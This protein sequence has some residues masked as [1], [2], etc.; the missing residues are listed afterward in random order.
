[1]A[2]ETDS[3]FDGASPHAF[4]S[5]SSQDYEDLFMPTEDLDLLMP[6]V[7]ELE[8]LPSQPPMSSHASNRNAHEPDIGAAQ[9]NTAENTIGSCDRE[10]TSVEKNGKEPKDVRVSKAARYRGGE[11]ELT[12]SEMSDR[13]KALLKDDG[14]KKEDA[15][16]EKQKPESPK[17]PSPGATDTEIIIKQE[18]KNS[19]PI[20]DQGT[21]AEVIDLSD[22]V[23]V[24]EIPRHMRNYKYGTT[25][26]D[27][28]ILLSDGEDD[29]EI[30]IVYD[31]GST[32]ITNKQE[33]PEV[34]FL[35]ASKSLVDLPQS[36]SS[37]EEEP[38]LAPKPKLD[39]SILRTP[40]PRVKRTPADIE[41][42]KRMQRLYAARALDKRVVTG[43]GGIFRTPRT[44]QNP[45]TT[46]S[47]SSRHTDSDDTFAWMSDTVI[48]DE[49]RGTGFLEL[50]R[51]YKAKRKARKNTLVDDVEFK[52]AQ[53]EENDRIRKLA[54]ETADSESDE[55]EESDDGLFVSQREPTSS[56]LKRPFGSIIGDFDDADDE[57]AG[58]D[59]PA[60]KKQKNN[61]PS[62]K[63]DYSNKRARAKALEKETRSNM[64]AGIE[65]YLLRDQKNAEDKAAKEAEIEDAKNGKGRKKGL[66][67]KKSGK[68]AK[69]V[70]P[71]RTATGRMN[72]V[73][74]LLT[75]NVYDDSNANLDCNSLPVITEKK[76]K[77]FLSSLIA[78]VPLEDQ[79]QARSDRI[80]VVRASK[81][82]SPRNV[83]PDGKGD[84]HLTGMKTSLYHYQVQGAAYMKKRETGDQEP[85]GG[86]LAGMSK[87]VL[88]LFAPYLGSGIICRED[89]SN[90]KHVSSLITHADFG[91]CRSDGLRQDC[92]DDCD[93]DCESRNSGKRA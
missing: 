49:N 39:N 65:A 20:S 21:P 19:L 46:D 26:Q 68:N 87:V 71:T 48:Q 57:V 7:M 29:Q 25:M 69:K 28:T 54:Q 22:S 89:S 75:S 37:A 43:A 72:N 5:N 15:S 27:G 92:D 51:V 8:D 4:G 91:R 83:K 31:D 67:K 16:A 32:A 36:E 35:G 78:N 55:A 13:I 82:L 86:I 64:M 56:F 11:A 2:S 17:E 50:K 58:T 47:N 3:P 85:C 10:T 63:V 33:N 9:Q 52:K 81:I 30:T 60:P 61:V 14:G 79:K 93:H 66:K 77:D 1:M 62:N 70:L 24:E 23:D 59:K 34:E 38:V 42:M 80:D 90:V 18:E 41:Q 88:S 84:W 74:S 76:K 73:G 40:N 12:A 53:R 45:Q 44:P 6:D